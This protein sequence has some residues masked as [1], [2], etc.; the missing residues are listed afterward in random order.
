MNWG[1]AEEA[2]RLGEAARHNQQRT[3]RETVAAYLEC[4]LAL[5]LFDLP[6]T[7]HVTMARSLGSAH[8]HLAAPRSRGLTSQ[9]PRASLVARFEA[10]G[11]DGSVRACRGL[12]DG[13]CENLHPRETSTST[14]ALDATTSTAQG[15]RHTPYPLNCEEPGR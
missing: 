9:M 6:L 11:A 2:K 12:P 1:F 13:Q 3:H 7:L 14:P 5:G 4:D 8:E 10:A 15:R